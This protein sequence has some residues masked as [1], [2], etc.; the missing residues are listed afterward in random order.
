[1]IS[2][3]SVEIQMKIEENCLHE[4]SLYRWKLYSWNVISLGKRTLNAYVL[5]KDACNNYSSYWHGGKSCLKKVSPKIGIFDFMNFYFQF[6]CKGLIGQNN[7]E[8]FPTYISI[9]ITA[10]FDIIAPFGAKI[11]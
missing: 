8:N 9:N 3:K 1:M 7:S 5:P 2:L 4:R 6:Q 11:Q 10:N